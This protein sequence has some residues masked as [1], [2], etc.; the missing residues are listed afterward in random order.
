MTRAERITELILD[1]CLAF[2]VCLIIT[3]L[4]VALHHGGGHHV[5]E[6]RYARGR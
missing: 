5:P 4:I 6:Y 3:L 2:A 1:A